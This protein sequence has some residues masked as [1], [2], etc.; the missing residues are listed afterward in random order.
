M[1]GSREGGSECGRGKVVARDL[2]GVVE[3]EGRVVEDESE[4]LT[5]CDVRGDEWVSGEGRFGVLLVL[6]VDRGGV[7]VW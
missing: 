2:N 7:G 6:D 5:E 4:Y 1:S 3:G